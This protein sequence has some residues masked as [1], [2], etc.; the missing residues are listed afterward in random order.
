MAHNQYKYI[1][2][3][4]VILACIVI[5]ATVVLGDNIFPKINFNPKAGGGNGFQLDTKLQQIKSGDIVNINTWLNKREL[6]YLKSLLNFYTFNTDTPPQGFKEAF[7]KASIISDADIYLGLYSSEDA[8]HWVINAGGKY[9]GY[10]DYQ[11]YIRNL[12]EALSQ[13]TLLYSDYASGLDISKYKMKLLTAISA[14]IS[15]GF[16]PKPDA[17]TYHKGLSVEQSIKRAFRI[18]QQ[19]LRQSVINQYQEEIFE[20]KRETKAFLQASH[21][22]CSEFL[23]L[24]NFNNAGLTEQFNGIVTFDKLTV[25]SL[26][27]KPVIQAIQIQTFKLLDNE[28]KR[29]SLMCYQIALL[30]WQVSL[31]TTSNELQLFQLNALYNLLQQNEK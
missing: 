5:P 18:K 23:S 19:G 1:L 14:G 16:I 3:I 10:N 26:F 27:Y 22:V 17:T 9:A 6:N 24:D 8:K 28:F 7:K 15:S 31:Q 29:L 21:D 20:Q 11:N 4:S 12:S 30:S 25:G 13:T 2:L